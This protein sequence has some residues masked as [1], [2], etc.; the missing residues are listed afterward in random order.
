[1]GVVVIRTGI[2]EES[3]KVDFC[4]V[5]LDGDHQDELIPLAGPG[6]WNDPDMVIFFSSFLSFHHTFPGRKAMEMEIGRRLSGGKSCLFPPFVTC[7]IGLHFSLKTNVFLSLSVDYRQLRTELRAIQVADGHLVHHG[8]ATV[9]VG[10]S[11]HHPARVQS[12]STKS[13]RH[14]H[15]SGSAGYSRSKSLQGKSRFTAKA[16]TARAAGP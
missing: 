16:G 10:G 6:H 4:F 8:V 11:A 7:L 9:D 12:H 1:M 14:R 5:F 2:I 15:Q 13:R 3:V